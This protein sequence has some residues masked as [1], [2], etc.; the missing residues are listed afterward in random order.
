MKKLFFTCILM[1]VIVLC[2]YAQKTPATKP[3]TAAKPQPAGG[4][5]LKNLTDS[6]SYALGVQI[7][8]YYKQQGVENINAACLTKAMNDVYKDAKVSM[9]QRDIDM[10]MMM[11]LSPDT[12]EKVKTNLQ[13]GEKFLVANK[14]KKGVTT[15]ASGLQYEVLTQGTGQKPQAQDTV[16]CNY[17]GTFLNGETFDESYS[18]GAPIEFA[19]TRVIKGWT[20]ALL[21]MPV[22]SKY[23]IYV[24]Y[25]LGYGVNDYYSIPGGSMLTF[26]IE[27]LSIKGK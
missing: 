11:K 27:L 9:Q 5:Q 17:K 7:A 3:A 12:Y 13:Q 19:C 23:K 20:E 1:N 26:E 24:P 2:A 16:V 8:N 10:V 14:T 25:D 6:F 18:K 4:I 15:T 22:G 21:M